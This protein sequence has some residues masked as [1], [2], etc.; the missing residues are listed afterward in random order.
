MVGDDDAGERRCCW[1]EK[2]VLV[3]EDGAGGTKRCC[4]LEKSIVVKSMTFDDPQKP[5]P[6][7]FN[8]FRDHCAIVWGL[9]LDHSESKKT[10]EH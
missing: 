5:F 8:Y 6:P 10:S 7:S 2:T 9:I 3:G 1:W 4:W